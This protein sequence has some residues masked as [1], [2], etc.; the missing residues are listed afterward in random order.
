MLL[1][2]RRAII[3]VGVFAIASGLVFISSAEASPLALVVEQNRVIGGTTGIR[4]HTIGWSFMA[5]ADLT[6]DALGTWGPSTGFPANRRV[7]LWNGDGSIMLAEVTLLAGTG[8]D[9]FVADPN[10]PVPGSGFYLNSIAPVLLSQ[11]EKYVL[12]TEHPIFNRY[13]YNHSDPGTGIQIATAPEIIYLGARAFNFGFGF[14][15]GS[16]TSPPV[17]SFGP[18]FTFQVDPPTLVPEPASFILW[19]VA[20]LCLASLCYVR[21]QSRS[22]G[23]RQPWVSTQGPG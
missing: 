15:A 19:S 5:S 9:I 21:Y 2:L 18:N 12:G 1:E 8:A 13:S 20:I 11:G 6:V 4:G 16:D 23:M 22:D 14:P 7:G 17:G 3:T 10:P